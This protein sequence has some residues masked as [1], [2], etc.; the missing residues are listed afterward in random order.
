MVL[1]GDA[2]ERVPH[3][4]TTTMA[5][6]GDG[7][8]DDASVSTTKDV[9]RLKWAQRCCGHTG[10]NLL[11]SRDLMVELCTITLDLIGTGFPRATGCPA[12]VC[13]MTTA[14]AYGLL[15]SSHIHADNRRLFDSSVYNPD[16]VSL[17]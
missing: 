11:D 2:V 6:A 14:S 15:W 13:D 3:F 9:T 12:E 7:R 5:V 1:G 10:R 16:C 4:R 17:L 8:M